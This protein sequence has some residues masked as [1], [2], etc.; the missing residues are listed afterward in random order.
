M[1]YR[2]KEAHLR[3]KKLF[4]VWNGKVPL[5][6]STEVLVRL[7]NSR[8]R[9]VEFRHC[10]YFLSCV[11]KK[12]W[13]IVLSIF[14]FLYCCTCS[15]NQSKTIYNMRV[16]NAK[17]SK[18]QGLNYLAQILFHKKQQKYIQNCTCK[19]KIIL[20]QFE[21]RVLVTQSRIV[22]KLKKT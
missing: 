17:T 7:L 16:G 5:M 13:N 15:F 1:T 22:S 21:T 2:R 20:A 9:N 3:E 4:F 11:F 8:G 10:I 14:L 12:S 6:F 18:M 19:R